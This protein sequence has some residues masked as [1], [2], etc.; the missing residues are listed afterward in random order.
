MRPTHVLAGLLGSVALAGCTAGGGLLGTN[1]GF[2]NAEAAQL[3]QENDIILLQVNEGDT[4]SAEI[5]LA[6]NATYSGF[7]HGYNGGGTGP[8]LE[9]FG[10]LDMTVDFNT[11]TIS[12]TISNVYTDLP[13]FLAPSGTAIVTGTIDNTLD[14]GDISIDALGTLVGTGATADYD[15]SGNGDFI[16]DTAQAAIGS[17]TTDL[18]WIGGP[19]TGT[20]SFSDGDWTGEQ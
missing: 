15:F 10:E 5:P 18:I 12:G 8:D 16:G 13:G 14:G 2:D 4:L 3:A 20:T 17:H 6:G 1:V 19:D 9:H 7:V 11:E